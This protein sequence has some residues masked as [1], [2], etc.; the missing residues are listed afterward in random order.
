MQGV[1]LYEDAL[2]IFSWTL[3]NPSEISAFVALEWCK[4]TEAWK[5]HEVR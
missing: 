2:Y 3:L 5:A 4:Y 1:N